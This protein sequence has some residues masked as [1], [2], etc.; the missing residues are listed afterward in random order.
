MLLKKKFKLKEVLI[1]FDKL[2]LNDIGLI[3][4]K[5]ISSGIFISGIMF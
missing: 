1:S 4:K 3:Y 5:K 2:M